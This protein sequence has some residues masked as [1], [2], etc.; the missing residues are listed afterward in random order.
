M[1]H[2]AGDFLGILVKASLRIHNAH[3]PQHFNSL[4]IRFGR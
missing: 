3:Y 4:I 2:I 1:F